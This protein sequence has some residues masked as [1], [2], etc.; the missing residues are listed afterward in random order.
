MFSYKLYSLNQN[1][2]RI[3]FIDFNSHK[4][5]VGLKEAQTKFS[6]SF[7]TS[8]K[9]IIEK[10]NTFLILEKI[11]G[12]AKKLDRFIAELSKLKNLLKTKN[13]SLLVS[14]IKKL[15]DFTDNHVFFL[16]LE[17][18]VRNEINRFIEEVNLAIL[19]N[20]SLE[21]PSDK[22]QSL[23][24]N[25]IN[26]N[27]TFGVD[28]SKILIS[29]Y[30]TLIN[31]LRALLV[32]NMRK[33][34]EKINHSKIRIKYIGYLNYFSEEVEKTVVNT[35]K[36]KYSLYTNFYQQLTKLNKITSKH[37][38]IVVIGEFVNVKIQELFT[39]FLKSLSNEINDLKQ[40][41]DF[42]SLCSFVNKIGMIYKQGKYFFDDFKCEEIFK[43]FEKI[44]EQVVDLAIEIDIKTGLS[45]K[46]SSEYLNVVIFIYSK[47]EVFMRDVLVELEQRQPKYIEKYITS[48]TTNVCKK[49]LKDYTRLNEQEKARVG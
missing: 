38:M 19:S 36:N 44:I 40:Q 37:N 34:S 20:L 4:V 39:Y 42:S 7:S 29:V 13:F 49:L 22:L 17:N 15:S 33:T 6:D 2:D 16:L 35:D 23:I 46:E 26:L 43:K 12:Y 9:R 47:I 10:K 8:F 48:L 41:N 30:E 3:F 11:Y 27:K 1:F 14:E 25:V 45:L 32:E 31:N 21:M 5:L 24:D 18:V 28:E